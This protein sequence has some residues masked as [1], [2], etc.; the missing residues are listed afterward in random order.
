[1]KY[2]DAIK[3]A[4][5]GALITDGEHIYKIIDPKTFSG[6]LPGFIIQRQTR[7][8]PFDEIDVDPITVT[9]MWRLKK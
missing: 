1:M 9:N 6:N 3:A 7:G 2:K 8:V 5:D 4:K